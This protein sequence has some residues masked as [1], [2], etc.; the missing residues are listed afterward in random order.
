MNSSQSCYKLISVLLLI[1]CSSTKDRVIAQNLIPDPGFEQT[2]TNATCERPDVGFKNLDLWYALNLNPD[3][4]NSSCDFDEIDFIY[5]SEST[6]AKEGS[7][8]IGLWSRWNSDETYKSEGIAIELSEPLQSGVTYEIAMQ[9]YNRGE[10]QGLSG[11]CILKPQKHLDIYLSSDSLRII[12]NFSNGTAMASEERAASLMSDDITGQE[13]EDWQ[14]ISTCFTAKGGEQFLGIVMPLG[15]FGNL[16][17]CAATMGTSGVFRSFYYFL[18][19]IQLIP[20]STNFVIDTLVC[21]GDKFAA[22]LTELFDSDLL[23]QAAFEWEDGSSGGFRVLEDAQDYIINA[24]T[25]CGNIPLNLR[26]LS[27]AC[28]NDVFVPNIFDPSSDNENKVLKPLN[29]QKDQISNYKFIV[30]DRWGSKIFESNDPLI[31]WDGLYQ[32]DEISQGN[33][34]WQISYATTELNQQVNKEMSGSVLL[35]R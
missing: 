25:N 27:E 23:D 33:Y 35:I 12:N 2:I 20:L 30:Y 14:K 21:E 16:P 8:Y 3:F 24:V 31:G 32:K 1:I 34:I 29:I 7:N 9:V 19:D 5:W 15:D 6:V 11:S 18:D 17:S 10:F 13:S 4:F 22:N 28:N 26:I